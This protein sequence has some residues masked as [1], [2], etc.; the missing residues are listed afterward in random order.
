MITNWNFNKNLESF[1]TWKKRFL[2][3]F[4]LYSVFFFCSAKGFNRVLLVF[5]VR[6]VRLGAFSFLSLKITALSF[7]FFIWSSTQSSLPWP[8]LT[9]TCLGQLGS[10][11][12]KSL[13]RFYISLLES[14][15]CHTKY[16]FL[17]NLFVNKRWKPTTAASH[18]KRLSF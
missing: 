13:H 17:I 12:P 14:Q 16:Y 3:V 2:F 15:V 5:L 1:G 4:L 8:H 18:S 6:W 7:F 11:K 10:Q 9:P